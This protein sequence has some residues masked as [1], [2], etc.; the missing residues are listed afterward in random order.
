MNNKKQKV[1]QMFD[2]IA[3]RYD[4][5]NHL[6]SFGI[7]FYWR[8]KALKLTKL[9]SDSILLDIACGTGDFAI[10]AKKYNLKKIFA[11]DVSINM[12]KL[13]NKKS[14]W[15]IGNNFQMAAE[16]IPL[17]SLSVSN[18]TVAFGVR[19]FYDIP[20]AFKEFLRIL[21][22]KGKVTILEFALPANFLI[23]FFYNL[24]FKYVLPIIGGI[25]SK[26]FKAYKYLPDSVQDFDKK[27]DLQKILRDTGFIDVKRINL[28]L[29][30]IQVVIAQK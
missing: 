22:P 5:L 6:L 1:K 17:K 21:K 2:G 18:I 23:R 13:F 25:I 11:A 4:F 19:N 20:T 27:V 15:I 14:E 7:D 9:I 10:N 16:Q 8:N 30:T 12:L 28:T 24:Y 26:D 3:S 29:G